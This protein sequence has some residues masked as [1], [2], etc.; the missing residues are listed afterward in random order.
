MQTTNYPIYE[1]KCYDF[2]VVDFTLKHA[3]AYMTYE[4]SSA[5][6]KTLTKIWPGG[7]REIL[8]QHPSQ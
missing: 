3:E 8:Q 6:F 4:Q 1:V 5:N 7:R 2:C